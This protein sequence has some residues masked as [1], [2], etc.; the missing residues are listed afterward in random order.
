MSQHMN[1]LQQML[2][3]MGEGIG[4]VDDV[5]Q[6]GVRDHIL[7]LP[8]DGSPLPDDARLSGLREALGYGM[9]QHRSPNAITRYKRHPDDQSN[10]L[11]LIGSRA[12]QVGGLAGVTAAGAALLNTGEGL[13]EASKPQ[14]G[15][16]YDFTETD[17]Q[18]M[19]DVRKSLTDGSLSEIELH[20]A[21]RNGA[22]TKPQLLLIS[23]IHDW[24]RLGQEHYPFGNQ[25]I[26]EAVSP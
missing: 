12:A 24:S 23:D 26:M 8:N 19:E 20:E 2:G 11:G 18:V 25:T 22:F 7:R 1:K 21:A 4:R 5:V 13:R 17:Y 9:H 3:A 16:L 15:P 14:K 6:G 10:P